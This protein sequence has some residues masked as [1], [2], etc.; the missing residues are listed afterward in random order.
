[1]H[2]AGE[3]EADKN[4][5]DFDVFVT[6]QDLEARNIILD[7]EAS[8]LD[9]LAMVAE[10]FSEKEKLMEAAKRGKA[11]IVDQY[12]PPEKK[13]QKNYKSTASWIRGVDKADDV[14]VLPEKDSKQAHRGFKLFGETCI[15][16]VPDSCNGGE[17]AN[18]IDLNVPPPPV[19]S[20]SIWRGECSWPWVSNSMEGF[21][22]LGNMVGQKRDDYPERLAPS[23][24]R[25]WDTTIRRR[26]EDAE[27][28]MSNIKN[29]K[30]RKTEST[31]N[32]FS[33]GHNIKT[34][35][36]K[37]KGK[38]T[39]NKGKSSSG[40]IQQQAALPVNPPV[41]DLPH[42]FKSKIANMTGIALEDINNDNGVFFLI[43]KP[44]TN[45]DMIPGQSRFSM[46]VKQVLVEEG[47]FLTEEERALLG[48]DKPGFPVKLIEPNLNVCELNF[49]RWPIG[50]NSYSYVLKTKW[51]Q[52][53]VDNNLRTN[54][55]IRVW[56]FRLR[57]GQLCFA[58]VKID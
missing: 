56:S 13:K 26:K 51:N 19:S 42:E 41:P 21:Y 2:G 45:S 18:N 12:P 6:L 53:K 17:R 16:V 43:Q 57:S 46:S 55:V 47:T 23:S 30:K 44:L 29:Q 48:K 22:G 58:M 34:T 11:A 25:S 32:Q 15:G 40:L 20:Q 9:V 36:T 3:Q 24:S 37:Y 31:T 5:R 33:D 39:T 27:A 50:T 54:D 28:I 8:R 4:D 14:L 49:Q 10:I 52:V 7:Q 38:K 1:M 35:S